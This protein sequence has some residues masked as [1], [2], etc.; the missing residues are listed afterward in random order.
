M[1][2]KE[3]KQ[4]F[5]NNAI[6]FMIFLISV[7]FTLSAVF[8]VVETN[9]SIINILID[10]AL[11]MI[12]GFIITGLFDI[13]GI[14]KGSQTVEV[15]EA[16]KNH[17]KAVEEVKPYG[18]FL[19]EHCELESKK[20]LKNERSKI[21]LAEGL[22]Y[23]MCFDENGLAK[24]VSKILVYTPKPEKIKPI[25][26]ARPRRNA[27]DYEE[28]LKEWKAEVKKIKADKVLK[29][30][31]KLA[32]LNWREDNQKIKD[33]KKAVKKATKVKIVELY[34]SNLI[35]HT[36]SKSRFD[37]GGDSADYLRKSSLS[38]ILSKMFM[39]LVLGYYTIKIISNFNAMLLFWN[40]LQIFVFLTFGTLKFYQAYIFMKTQNAD[41]INK[42][43]GELNKFLSKYKKITP[44]NEIDNIVDKVISKI[45]I[46]TE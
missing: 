10:S 27:K 17:A 19:D 42:R 9:R 26:P 2:G 4:F 30:Q 6:Y 45:E 36:K 37:F 28:L 29:S 46:T 43:T 18:N 16:K 35:G 25:L 22:T 21:L 20:E 23:E 11:I 38:S 39:S 3:T 8:E 1:K 24:D 44:T 7:I 31:N 15:V 41:G 33:K 5:I 32:L 40:V 12:V 13:Q 14:F 34:T